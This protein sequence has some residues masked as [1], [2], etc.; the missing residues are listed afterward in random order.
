LPV[1]F[2]VNLICHLLLVILLA[3]KTTS[4]TTRMAIN[5]PTPRPALN[6]PSNKPQE[7]M[8]RASDIIM[9]KV[10]NLL[11]IFGYRITGKYLLNFIK[12]VLSRTNKSFN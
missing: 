6:I 12:S 10:M 5:I 7:V 1:D 3:I 9:D 2:A 4:A 11:E 8:V